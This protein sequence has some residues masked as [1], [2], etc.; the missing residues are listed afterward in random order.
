MASDHT[1]MFDLD[2]PRFGPAAGGAA[3]HL[4]I[5]LHG[6]GADGDDLIGLAPHLARALPQAA[7]VS[8]HA[9]FPCDLAPSGRQWFSLQDHSQE[10]MLAGVRMAA[11]I[12][13]R[14][15]DDEL[16]R[17]RLADDRLALVGFSQ[18]TMTG[19][20]TALRRAK[21]CAAVVGFS[22]HLVGAEFLADEIRS[23]PPVLLVHGD[24]DQVV[25]FRAMATAVAALEAIQVPVS[26]HRRPGLGHGIDDEG[27]ALAA[28][29]LV[30]ALSD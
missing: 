26:A 23:R 10:A 4:V 16:A 5:L 29:A 15:I 22:G 1:R 6:L 30:D 12:L 14:F 20:F 28:K 27:L 24:G 19:L 25:P 9:P 18:G 13:E 17:H 7:F 21:A 8:P 3:R 2:G 11:P